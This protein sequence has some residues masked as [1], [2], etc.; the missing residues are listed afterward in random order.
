MPAA[1][2]VESFK[3][4]NLMTQLKE[5]EKKEQTKPKVTRRKNKMLKIGAELNKTETKK[6]EKLEFF[7]KT[8]KINKPCIRLRE[9]KEREALYE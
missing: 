5:L 3:I 4:N 9:N 7:K 1:K 8:N 2:K 6:T